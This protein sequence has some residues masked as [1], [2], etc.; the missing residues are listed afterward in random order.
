MLKLKS[1]AQFLFKSGLGSGSADEFRCEECSLLFAGQ[2]MM[3]ARQ[4]D[5]KL[6]FHCCYSGLT[7]LIHFGILICC[8]SGMLNGQNL[9]QNP[10]FESGL[11]FWYT[12]KTV[13]HY[14]NG[15]HPDHWVG[16][17]SAYDGSAFVGLRTYHDYDEWHEYIYQNLDDTLLAGETYK[18][19]F[20]L[21]LAECST[22]FTDDIGVAFLDQNLPNGSSDPTVIIHQATPQTYFP[23]NLW[24]D[25]VDN[26][27]EFA[28]YFEAEGD[29]V[30]IA[31]GS[32]KDDAE[33]SMVPYNHP[34]Y[35][36]LATIY[37]NVDQVALRRCIDY[38][39]KE[40]DDQILCNDE[41]ALVDAF[42]EDATYRWSTGD[43]TSSIDVQNAPGPY[44]VAIM[45]NGCQFTEHFEVVEYVSAVLPE[46]IVFCGEMPIP[47]QLSVA[48][49]R[50][51]EFLWD[52]G[53]VNPDRMVDEA[54]IYWVIKQAGDCFSTDSISI[55]VFEE[56]TLLF[57]NPVRSSDVK[58]R[59]D[60]DVSSFRLID[61][62]GKELAYGQFSNE[63]LQ[64][65]TSRLAPGTYFLLLEGL[66][67]TRT[68]KFV[69]I[70]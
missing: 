21:N 25:D 59:F 3:N 13:D 49:S 14:P 50:H 69:L 60:Q 10:S 15:I 63:L 27:I 18:V 1:F 47:V 16:P 51:D 4:L 46:D 11:S 34:D 45:K 8:N 57:P 19:S 6:F 48:T 37:L 12:I 2:Q 36:S 53:S 68:L 39:K 33:M 54:G 61:C 29:E 35:G 17:Q 28:G 22:S 41:S 44:W 70:N 55:T 66:S 58:I 30:L 56:S 24:I 31:I 20:V 64:H 42:V 52:D 32:F 67:C 40:I 38:P 26:W 5:R 9:I 43:T 62:Q 7:G 65:E 23:D